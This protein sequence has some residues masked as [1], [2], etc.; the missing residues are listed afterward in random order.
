MFKDVLYLRMQ[1]GSEKQVSASE[2][3]SVHPYFELKPVEVEKG[4]IFS[5]PGQEYFLIKT[6]TEEI[7]VPR[8]PEF[9][10]NDKEILDFIFANAE[11]RRKKNLPF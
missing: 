5:G 11:I 3:I 8:Y 10:E 9:P 6:K 4:V 2:L 1:D 7:K